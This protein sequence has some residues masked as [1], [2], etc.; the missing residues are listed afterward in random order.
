MAVSFITAP[1]WR[2]L[3][4]IDSCTCIQW[5]ATQKKK[6]YMLMHALLRMK[7]K[8]PGKS[9]VQMSDKTIKPLENNTHK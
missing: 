5:N 6:K 7:K 2:K 8:I 3:K 4:W 1:N 9:H